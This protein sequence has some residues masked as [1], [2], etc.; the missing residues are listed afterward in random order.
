M[1]SDA[2]RALIAQRMRRLSPQ[3]CAKTAKSA[4]VELGVD[5]GALMKASKGSALSPSPH[6]RRANKKFE[7]RGGSSELRR[8]RTPLQPMSPPPH[9]VSRR[10]STFLSALRSKSTRNLRSRLKF[11]MF[12]EGQGTEEDGEKTP[13]TPCFR[14]GELKASRSIEKL[15]NMCD[16]Y[17]ELI[18]GGENQSSFQSLSKPQR[19]SPS[20]PL[21]LKSTLIPHKVPEDLGFDA[22]TVSQS[23]A[24]KSIASME[25]YKHVGKQTIWRIDSKSVLRS[26]EALL[27]RNGEAKLSS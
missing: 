12:T 2:H 8:I 21:R 10:P 6:I 14:V 23:I 4:L 7:N 22:E 3:N 24:E 25:V 18:R 20:R 13:M 11:D 5:V 15:L 16:N 27:A 19:F 1:L 17:Q 9:S 26:T